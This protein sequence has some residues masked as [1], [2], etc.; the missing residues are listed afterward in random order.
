MATDAR[1]S[2]AF[3]S[4]C[5]DRRPGSSQDAA[6][7]GEMKKFG[8]WPNR[9]TNPLALTPSLAMTMDIDKPLDEVIA[10]DQTNKGH[11]RGGRNSNLSPGG[12]V[13]ADVR[14]P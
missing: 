13:R 6:L 3:S 8:M 1:R 12:K 14:R 10:A 5:G 7:A 11:R 4:A 9:G 2:R